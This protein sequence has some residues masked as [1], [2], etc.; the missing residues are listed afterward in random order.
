MRIEA[1]DI[2]KD[3]KN[4]MVMKGIVGCRR[5]LREPPRHGA[6]GQSL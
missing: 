2:T 5:K 4:T 6:S 3:E 1:R